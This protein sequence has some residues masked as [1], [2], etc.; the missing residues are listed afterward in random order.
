MSRVC[1]NM[2]RYTDC[3]YTF[4]LENSFREGSFMIMMFSNVISIP[5][6]HY[7]S[8]VLEVLAEN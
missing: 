5:F 3:M 2:S 8:V 7:I 1:T 4:S 6:E